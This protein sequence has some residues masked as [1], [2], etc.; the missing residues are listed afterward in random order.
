[1]NLELKEE[2]RTLLLEVLDG[3]LG[4]LREEVHHSRVF[5]FTDELKKKEETLRALIDR[6]EV[7]G[8]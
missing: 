2:E 1:M 7:A 3:R 4:E 6:V 5:R 8:R